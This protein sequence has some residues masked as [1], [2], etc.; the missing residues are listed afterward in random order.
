V[1]DSPEVTTREMDDRRQ[2][3]RRTMRLQGRDDDAVIRDG[4]R[5]DDPDVVDA[6]P[7]RTQR[8]MC[9]CGSCVSGLL[10]PADTCLFSTGAVT[11][12]AL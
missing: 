10:Q 5:V 9:S 8:Y 11:F 1:A 3:G 7:D 4:G 12:S 6:W 2:L